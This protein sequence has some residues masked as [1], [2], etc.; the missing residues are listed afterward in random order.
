VDKTLQ[1]LRDA[2][3]DLFTAAQAAREYETAYHALC[4]A[5]HAAESLGDQET[6]S[7]VALRAAEC[8]DWIDVEAPRHRLSTQSAQSRGHESIFRQLAVLAD[9][10]RLRLVAEVQIKQ[11][12]P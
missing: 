1:S 7:L 9:A 11:G 5:L 6:C 3:I 2:A 4:A 8:R 10:A 12:R